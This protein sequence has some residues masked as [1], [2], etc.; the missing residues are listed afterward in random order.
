VVVS[1]DDSNIYVAADGQ[2]VVRYVSSMLNCPWLPAVDD[3]YYTN[4][5]S[6][7]ALVPPLPPKPTPLIVPPETP[8]TTASGSSGIGGIQSQLEDLSHNANNTTIV[9]PTAGST[10]ERESIPEESEGTYIVYQAVDYNWATPKVFF[11]AY[12]YPSPAVWCVH[13]G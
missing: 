11:V 1:N 12:V 2:E 9:Q 4:F 7:A 13:A 3:T 8:L 5:E 6:S 10:F